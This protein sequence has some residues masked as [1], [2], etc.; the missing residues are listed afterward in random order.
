MRFIKR[1]KEEYQYQ[2]VA[3]LHSDS[4]NSYLK[5]SE[6]GLENGYKKL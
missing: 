3:L 1:I 4:M 2:D 6:E 5:E